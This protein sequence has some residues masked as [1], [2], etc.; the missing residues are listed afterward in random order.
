[1][2]AE[3]SII[4]VIDIQEE[5]IDSEYR[6]YINKIY[7]LISKTSIP[8]ISFMF[9]NKNNST[10]CTELNWCKVVDEEP[11]LPDYLRTNSDITITRFGYDGTASEDFKDYVINNEINTCYLVGCEI[12]ACVLSTAFGIFNMNI[13]PIIIKDCCYTFASEKVRESSLNVLQRNIGSQNII[14]L[15]EVINN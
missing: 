11:S 15:S 14:E 13:R 10:Y 8:V 4:C 3:N 9:K 12:D 5:F 6:S 1:M 7:K 2:V